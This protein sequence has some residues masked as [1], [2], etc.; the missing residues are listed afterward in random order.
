MGV[1]A[2]TGS[3]SGMGHQVAQKLRDAGHT[4]IGVN[5]KQADITADLLT[6]QGRQAA[7][8]GVLAASGAKLDGAVLAAGLGP[9][10]ARS[11]RA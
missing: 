10:R 3:A 4:V 8:A 1:Y 11:V 6:A 2:V 5:I 7:A 9:D